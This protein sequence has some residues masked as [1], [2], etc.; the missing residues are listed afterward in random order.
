MSSVATSKL[1][2]LYLS[3]T[4][5][6][7]VGKEHKPQVSLQKKS[8]LTAVAIRT[9]NKTVLSTCSETEKPYP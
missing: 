1:K 6:P 3:Y 7:G 4:S 9:R 5:D 8:F 2:P